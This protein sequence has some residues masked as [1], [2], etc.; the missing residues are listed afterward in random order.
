[1]KHLI[2]QWLNDEIDNEVEFDGRIITLEYAELGSGG[3]R[4]EMWEDGELIAWVDNHKDFLNI[5]LLYH[6]YHCEILFYNIP[7]LSF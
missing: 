4:Y 3:Q 2:Q 7:I 5:D 6:F 1:M